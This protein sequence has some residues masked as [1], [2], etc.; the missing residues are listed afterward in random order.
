VGKANETGPRRRFLMLAGMGL[1]A[2]GGLCSQPPVE[3]QSGAVRCHVINWHGRELPQYKL[4]IRSRGAAAFAPMALSG[5]GTAEFRLPYG[6]YLLEATASLHNK[7]EIEFTVDA[8]RSLLVISL[9]PS[10]WGESA[11]RYTELSGRVAGGTVK[12]EKRIVR[13]VS[14]FGDFSRYGAVEDD[15]SFAIADVPDGE[16]LLLVMDGF[17]ILREMRVSKTPQH[18][19]FMVTLSTR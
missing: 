13:I 15:G 19:E 18:S 9:P 11:V 16:Y 8:A 6:T 3:K 14:L 10:N 5:S 17:R 4:M 2:A 12:R 7:T 1:P